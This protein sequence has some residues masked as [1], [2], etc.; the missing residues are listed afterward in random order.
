[1]TA[2]GLPLFDEGAAQV[3]RPL[4]AD[5]QLLAALPKR[6][7]T[8]AD[9]DGDDGDVEFSSR[10]SALMSAGHLS[11]ISPGDLGS[12]AF[13]GIDD[14]EVAAHGVHGRHDAQGGVKG[15]EG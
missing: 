1:M 9:G 4:G 10:R 5:E 2:V 14:A 13:A 7:R 15:Q 8:L 3:R 6:V 11:V 12:G